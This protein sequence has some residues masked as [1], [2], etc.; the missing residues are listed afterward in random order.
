MRSPTG[1]PEGWLV[2]SRIYAQCRA[3]LQSTGVVFT[4]PD[5]PVRHTTATH[6]SSW[7]CGRLMPWL[8]PGL[9]VVAGRLHRVMGMSPF[10]PNIKTT[11]TM[12]ARIEVTDSNEFNIK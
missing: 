6:S 12:I 8:P 9:G 10:R 4:E 7:K 5:Q 11:T 1:Q 3:R 2:H